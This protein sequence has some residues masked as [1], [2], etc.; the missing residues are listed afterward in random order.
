MIPCATPI[1]RL[2]GFDRNWSGG[3]SSEL[4]FKRRDRLPF[5]ERIKLFFAPRKGWRRGIEYLS[6]RMQRLPDSAESIALGFACGV[7]ASF[8]PFFGFHFVVAAALAWLFRANLYA[9]AIGTFFGNPLTFGFIM[10]F[11]L[12]L[13]GILVGI[14]PELAAGLK[15]MDFVDKL[16]LLLTNIPT[17]V[18]PYFV[19]GFIPGVVFAVI[20]FYLLRPIVRAYQRRRRNKLME[21]AKMRLKEPL[22]ADPAE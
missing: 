6:L 20:S 19:G 17:L 10:Y 5:G 18:V 2:G 3:S 4:V 21:R 11:C 14:D 16:V 7:Y 15:S 9:S 13:G 1:A 12:K 8:T 22:G